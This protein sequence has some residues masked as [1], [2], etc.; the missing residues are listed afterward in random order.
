MAFNEPF[1]GQGRRH[2]R[3]V[4]EGKGSAAESKMAG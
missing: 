4:G 1:N 2:L 3:Q